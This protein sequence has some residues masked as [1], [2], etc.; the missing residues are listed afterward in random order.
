KDNSMKTR[1]NSYARSY[2]EQVND[3]AT[4]ADISQEAVGKLVRQKN[5]RRSRGTKINDNG[6]NL[7]DLSTVS[8]SGSNKN[9]KEDVD[10]R[11]KS[12]TLEVEDCCTDATGEKVDE[13][14]LQGTLSD[15]KEKMYDS[16]WEDG[17]I[18]ILDSAGD[19]QV[20]IEFNKTPDSQKRKPVR[21]ASADD[22]E[23]A[24][25][26]HKVH[27]LCL[28][29][30]GRL[31][32]NACDD[33]LIQASLLSLL[34]KHLLDISKVAK[35][36]AKDL[37]P[38]IFW[39]QNNFHVRSSTNVSRS[40]SS[41]LT[42][43]L[44]T[45]EGTSEEIAALA[46]A[47]FRAL[48]LTTRFVSILD[49][50]SLKPDVDKSD[51]LWQEASSSSKG[52]FSTST[53]M[54]ARQNEIS[55]S[56]GKSFSSNERKNAGETSWRSSCRSMDGHSTSNCQPEDS[57]TNEL[58]NKQ[59]SS[60]ACE[61][62]HDANEACKT[63]KSGRP[64]RKGDIEFELQMEMALSAT[65]VRTSDVAVNKM[66]SQENDSNNL[67]NLSSPW[68]RTKKVPTDEASSSHGISTAIGSKRVGSPLYWVEVYCTGEN[69][70]GKWVHIDAIN[71]VIDG[72]ERVEAVAA[73]CKIA[74]RYVVA[75][76]GN[77]AKD[78]TR[79]YCMKWYKIASQRVNSI[80]WESVLAPLREIES[81]ATGGV[82]HFGTDHV[83]ASLDNDNSRSYLE[84]MELETRALTEPLP[85]NQQIL[86]PRGPIL[87]FCSGH[88][89]YPRTCVH[90]LKTKERWLR[91]GLQVKAGELPAKDAKHSRKLNKLKASE[92]E[93]DDDCAGAN[94]TGTI[95]LYGKWQLEP[96]QLP[97]AVNG[98][99]PKNERG[100]VD[101][102]S[103]KCLP[104]G[105]VH[106][107]F[108]RIFAIAKRLEIDYAPAM[109]GFEFRN[110][111]SYPVFDGIVVCT[112]FKDAI[113]EAYGEEQERREAEE[114]KRNEMQ[115]ISR[116]YQLLSSI[117]TRQRLKN[118]YGE[119]KPSLFSIGD[120]AMKN[121][122]DVQVSGSKEDKQS[123]GFQHGERHENKF[124]TPS[125]EPQEDHEHVFLT[126]NQSF[127]E[128]NLL[129]TKRCYCGFSIQVEE[130]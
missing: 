32:N 62:K 126:E 71:A 127:D 11:V 122:L 109:V 72:E 85:T 54:V 111:Q 28:L 19:H 5:N 69:L 16:D 84:D 12:V 79:R 93:D 128:E 125:F 90:T 66:G 52:I 68:K 14:S 105:T 36:T 42:F 74:L 41:A 120:Q 106:L 102:W 6:I 77:G 104:P 49:V 92:D 100:Q 76:A 1:R 83:D 30:R 20:T 108:P 13:R 110:G 22:K 17:S 112:E 33:P 124:N 18:P 96:L 91:E 3:T 99:V 43:A 103:E 25:I 10:L 38:L 115:A 67:S 8:T 26:V 58:S 107:R 48:S 59:S 27:L 2:V 15:G 89:V 82:I 130:L 51:Q 87:G 117:V 119:N 35:L 116:W 46:V 21:R 50:A 44:E 31:I 113:L 114:K 95:K 88:P 121:N 64:K 4:F 56:P 34:P 23:L 86:H 63:S 47:L 70:T 9:E 73:A 7:P 94:S 57:L 24:E 98:I 53:P 81:R 60:L 55:V 129:L 40:F 45:R 118:R 39:F 65:A 123:V 97:H 80:W 61:P 75:F 101:V 37:Q 78:V 29:G